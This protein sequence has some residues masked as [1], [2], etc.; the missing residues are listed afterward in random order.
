MP[1][2][3][4]KKILIRGKSSKKPEREATVRGK[5]PVLPGDWFRPEKLRW[6]ILPVLSLV[7]SVL[8]FPNILTRPKIYGIG[9]VAENDI[10]ASQDFLI[11]N[12]ELTEKNREEAVKE[13]LSIYDF[14]NSAS[15]IASRKSP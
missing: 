3:T 9:D 6:L 15:H 7:I 4:K 2:K 10:K 1:D 8:L 11:E 12:R 13:V 14:D 5:P